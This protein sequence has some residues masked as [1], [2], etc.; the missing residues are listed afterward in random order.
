[1]HTCVLFAHF[2]PQSGRAIDLS[3]VA[4]VRCDAQR[5]SESF[6]CAA[7]LIRALGPVCSFCL[8]EVRSWIAAQICFHEFL[9]LG[10]CDVVAA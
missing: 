2:G 3:S 4:S 1:M 5:A 6:C 10:E 8:G 7:A 9:G